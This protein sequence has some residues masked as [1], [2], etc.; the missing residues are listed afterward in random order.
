MANRNPNTNIPWKPGQSGNPSGR[1]RMQ[2]ISDRYAHI[3]E[4]KL[5]E[6]IRNAPIFIRPMSGNES[7]P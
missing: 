2:P 1:P 5:P 7:F 3:A 4:E 6:S